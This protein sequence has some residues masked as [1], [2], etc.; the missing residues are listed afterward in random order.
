VKPPGAAT[1]ARRLA[2]VRVRDAPLRSL[3][4]EELRT[5]GFDV[6]ERRASGKATEPDLLVVEARARGVAAGV[7]D[8]RSRTAIVTVWPGQDPD[9]VRRSLCIATGAT[10]LLTPR[11][12]G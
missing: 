11:R 6:R 12:T 3:I 8:V 2:L 7:P 1:T 5:L 9:A 10:T 4:R